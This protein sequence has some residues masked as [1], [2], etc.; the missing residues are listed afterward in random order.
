M[1][2]KKVSIFEVIDAL[3]VIRKYLRQSYGRPCKDFSPLCMICE[4]WHHFKWVE[5]FLKTDYY[6]EKKEMKEKK[7]KEKKK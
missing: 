2:K 7:K 1:A 6:L 5:E 4:V 3:K